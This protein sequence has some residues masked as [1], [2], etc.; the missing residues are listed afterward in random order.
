MTLKPKFEK[1]HIL[2]QHMLDALRDYPYDLVQTLFNEM[3]NGIITGLKISIPDETHFEVSSGIVKIDGEIYFLTDSIVLPFEDER[4]YVYLDKSSTETEDGIVFK[5]NIIQKHDEDG[6][7]FEL[8]RYIKNATVKEYSDIK[9][10]CNDEMTNRIDQKF[11]LKSVV[12]GSTLRDNYYIL[13]ADAILKN[14]NANIRDISFAYQCLNGISHIG[15]IK[16]YFGAEN[17]TNGEVIQL[18]KDKVQEMEYCPQQIPNN[19][20]DR[21]PE[22]KIAIS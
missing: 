19:V 13:F 16:T 9:E 2:K 1:G 17:V 18:M 10:A 11:A 12:G 7:L 22:P 14:Q 21:R 15:L 5:T 6:S 3:G 4:N 20:P 8:F